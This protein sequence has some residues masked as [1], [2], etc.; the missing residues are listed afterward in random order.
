MSE[1]ERERFGSRIGFVMV[2]AGCA[3]GLG[4]VWK[5]PY[6]CGENG[7]GAF[8][9]IYLLCLI[10]LACPILICEL[11]V[12]RAS[13]RS[14]VRAF[15]KLEPAG[16]RWH[17]GAWLCVVGNYLLMMFYTCVC[18]WMLYYFVKF[19]KGDF[20]G[21]DVTTDAV[22]LQFGNMLGAPWGMTFATFAIIIIAFSICSFGVQKGVEKVTKSMMIVLFALLGVLAVHSLMLPEAA[23]G[24]EF[25]LIPNFDAVQKIGIGTVVFNAMSQAFFT[26]SIGIGA[27]S[28][29]GS[30]L[31]KERSLTGEALSIA[32]LDTLVA[33]MAG[34]IIIPACFSFGINP[35]SGPSLIFITMPNVFAQMTGGQIWGSLF[36][37]FL[38]FAALSTI[39]AVFENII[40]FAMD[41]WGWRRKKTISI[42]LI[43]LSVLSMPCILGFNILSDIQPLG[44]GSTIL[45]LEDF[46]VSNNILP[47]GALLY[48]LFCVNKIGW[49]WEA[50][51]A[52]A[53][54]G[55]GLK[56]PQKF[57]GFLTL[58][59]P[60]LITVIYLKG[61]YDLFVEKGTA[62]LITW[63]LV[64]LILLGFIAYISLYRKT[65][66]H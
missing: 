52:E 26:L 43:A 29:F 32:G 4:N 11:S 15:K 53:D 36:F 27:M 57:R 33:F 65:K 12:G 7:G 44:A 10:L 9:L 5:F 41:L 28:I 56:F 17:L 58:G 24:I 34:L 1:K 6:L 19:I 48:L 45:D 55:K 42:N 16:T 37:L 14:C 59:V 8:V 64:A 18:G 63:M 23:K 31:G 2:S 47:L 30:Y 61:Y 49:G 66:E 13:Q 51:K 38:V 54:T 21:S 25:Y 62:Y 60:V 35:G 22:T 40:A 46:I 50:F 20:S 3:V 39:I